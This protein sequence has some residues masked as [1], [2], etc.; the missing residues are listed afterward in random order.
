MD[1]LEAPG[2]N[3]PLFI[4]RPINRVETALNLRTEHD[5]AGVQP[6]IEHLDNELVGL[7]PVKDRIKEIAV[8]LLVKNLKKKM[9]LIDEKRSTS[10]GLHMSFTGASGTGKTSVAVRMAEILYRLGYI[11][12]G[13]VIT[14]SR[15]DLVGQ[16]I[17][18][19]APKTR[20]VLKR[21][22]GGVLFIDNAN[23]IY[24]PDNE[25]DYGAEAIEIL[26]QV[27]ENSR[28]DI[29]VI[30]AGYKDPM[31]TFYS[32]NPGL[33]SRVTHHIHFPDYTVE[34]LMQIAQVILSERNSQLS[35]DAE[36]ALA[37]WLTAKKDAQLFANA[38]TVAAGIDEGLKNH[39]RRL[40]NE[41]MVVTKG[42]LV[43][44]LKE[45]IPAV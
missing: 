16:F 43:S 8:L 30:L 6:V 14:V 1:L 5:N 36:E 18:H 38:R 45:D 21:A 10:V 33:S 35:S 19:T 27:M 32:S 29:V 22:M 23:S 4:G 24:R 13:Q 42:S 15:D 41:N 26:L 34:E 7:A 12:K 3:T 17:G 31:D 44:L 39:A 25:R 11:S 40:M 28:N 9:G 37:S 20:N 2:L